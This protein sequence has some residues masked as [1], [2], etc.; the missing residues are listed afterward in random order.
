M[1]GIKRFLLVGSFVAI[2]LGGAGDKS[3][4]DSCY[5]DFWWN[6]DLG[7]WEVIEVCLVDGGGGA[8]W[9]PPPPPWEPPPIEP[10]PAPEPTPPPA[11]QYACGG[12]QA[13]ERDTMR[14]EYTARGRAP[15]PECGDLRQGGGTTYFSWGEYNAGNPHAH[16]WV[17]GALESGADGARASYGQPL[18]V[19]SVYRCP[20]HNE[21][22]GGASGSLH[23]FGRAMDF[24]ADA[25]SEQGIANAISLSSGYAITYSDHAHV[26]GQW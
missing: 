22:V 19:T 20:E 6:P 14:D 18:S 11:P 5:S 25:S 1:A 9:E 8:G 24:A 21:N 15:V 23:Q 10:E 16:G 4:A 17:T 12:S 3:R 7:W 2:G 13:D 26:H